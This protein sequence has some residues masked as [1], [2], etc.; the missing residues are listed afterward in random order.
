MASN[1][2]GTLLAAFVGIIINHFFG[3][4][5]SCWRYGFFLGGLMGMTGL[6]MRYHVSETPIFNAV[7]NEKQKVRVPIIEV[8]VE[9]WRRLL[10]IAFLGAATSS[11]AYMIRGYLNVF[12]LQVMEYSVNEALYLKSFALF[13]MIIMLP[14]FGI[15]ADKVGYRKFLYIVCYVIV[16]SA[17]PIFM[18]IANENHDVPVVLLGLFL[19]GAIA[20][21]VCAPAYPYAIKAFAP[22]LRYSGV[23][24]SWNAGIAAFGGTT[25]VISAFLSEKIANY[26]PGY[27]M[28]LMATAFIIVSYCTRKDKY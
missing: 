4:D 2:V 15:I 7:K 9:K 23:A 1:M 28:M 13:N 16:I 14:I 19:I 8:I 11:I 27:Y 12:F 20:A 24:F 21:A 22:E 10:V 3:G 25:P 26:A 18:L 5:D 6:Y 17:I